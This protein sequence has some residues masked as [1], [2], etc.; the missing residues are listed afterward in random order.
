[1][2]PILAQDLS[3]AQLTSVF[4]W[5]FFEHVFLSFVS[6]HPHYKDTTCE[7]NICR[8]DNAKRIPLYWRK[9]EATPDPLFLQILFQLFAILYISCHSWTQ[10]CVHPSPWLAF[11]CPQTCFHSPCH[12]TVS[13][14]DLNG[15]WSLYEE[16]Y[17]SRGKTSTVWDSTMICLTRYA[18][19]WCISSHFNI[20]LDH[21]WLIC[22]RYWGQ[23]G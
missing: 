11:P 12:L 9:N 1:M 2:C 18:E 15:V 5:Y 4:T 8:T 17:K 19:S 23:G 10:S 3:K 14:S 7:N 22:D 21:R 20:Y 6:V 16:E 13:W